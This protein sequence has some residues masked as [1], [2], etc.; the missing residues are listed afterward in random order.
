M[1]HAN[2]RLSFII[3]YMTSYE[4]K[5]RMANKKGL[6]DAAKM[7]E[8]FAIEVC[9]I[10]FN[11]TFYNMNIGT[12]TYPYIDLMS[13]NKEILVQVSTAQD[14]PQK[15]KSTLEKIKNNTDQKYSDINNVIFFVLSND[16]IANIKKYIGNNQIGNIPFTVKNN[17]ITTND[18]IT[19]AENDFEFQKKLYEVL[20]REYDNINVNLTNFEQALECSRS[21]LANIEE[22]I[23]GEYKIDRNKFLEK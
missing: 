18:I 2:E 4:E 3:E 1:L 21:G 9:N 12:S 22:L 14:V 8:L 15:I 6:F 13:E 7:F 23:N 11:Q 5:I 20:K 19:K 16:S 10:W 17:L